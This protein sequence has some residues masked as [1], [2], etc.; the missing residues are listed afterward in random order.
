MESTTTKDNEYFTLSDLQRGFALVVGDTRARE[1]GKAWAQ[2]FA[3]CLVGDRV[4]ALPVSYGMKT[5]D[6][7]ATNCATAMDGKPAELE[8]LHGRRLIRFAPGTLTLVAAANPEV[9]RRFDRLKIPY[10]WA[11][12]D[13]HAQLQQLIAFLKNP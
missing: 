2:V 1:I 7:R 5:L 13:D 11:T 4:V 10:G 3:S 12:I 9:R 6:Q 8:T